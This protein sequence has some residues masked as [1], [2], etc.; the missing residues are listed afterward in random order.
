ME[1]SVYELS[2]IFIKTQAYCSSLKYWVCFHLL[3][4][5][6]EPKLVAE[7]WR[8]V[9]WQWGLESHLTSTNVT[10]HSQC[11]GRVS[12]MLEGGGKQAY[13]NSLL[14]GFLVRALPSNRWISLLV[15]LTRLVLNHSL[16]TNSHHSWLCACE[17]YFLQFFG[18][19]ATCFLGG[20]EKRGRNCVTLRLL[21]RVHWTPK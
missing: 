4:Q 12:A 9:P 2:L 14:S 7:K 5:I 19:M 1:C 10:V 3:V 16:H 20:R 18:C 15:D 13:S 8:D 17:F 6:T 11:F 21:W